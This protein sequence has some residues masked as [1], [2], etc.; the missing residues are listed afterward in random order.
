[1]S[2]ISFFN[3]DCMKFM[4]TKPDNYSDLAI[5]D[6]NYGI[7][8]SKW[9]ANDSMFRSTDKWKNCKKSG[10]TIKEWDME[11]V[12]LEIIQ[13]IKRC[14]KN[15][16]IFG[17]NY[18]AD[19][20]GST[21]GCI[22]WNKKTSGNFSDCEIAYVSN[23]GHTKMFEW[24]W[25]GFQKQKPEKRIHPSQKPVSLYRWILQ[26]YASEGMKILDT[27]GGSMSI[28]IACDLEGF[29]LDVCEIDKEYFDAGKQRYEQ[30][31]CQF[32]LF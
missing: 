18:L 21:K 7:G 27:H 29:D 12:S 1:M 24:L 30:H 20:L 19:L 26:N 14:S 16:I 8:V 28:A 11:R 23:A 2:V 9:D 13:E 31:K 5:V 17:Y 10:Y 22:V 32:R 15:Q 3:I 25:N 6:P 4:A